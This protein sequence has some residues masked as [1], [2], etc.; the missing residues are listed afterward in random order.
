MTIGQLTCFGERLSGRAASAW[1]HGSAS[2]G[3]WSWEV[4]ACL[5]SP[6]WA[7]RCDCSGNDLPELIQQRYGQA[8]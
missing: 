4:W 6:P 3:R 7:M 2:R 1:C 5:T 8:L